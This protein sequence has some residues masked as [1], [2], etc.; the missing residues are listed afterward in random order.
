MTDKQPTSGFWSSDPIDDNLQAADTS[1]ATPELPYNYLTGENELNSSS[2]DLDSNNIQASQDL[3]SSDSVVLKHQDLDISV[4]ALAGEV[5]GLTANDSNGKTPW[6]AQLILNGKTNEAPYYDST[7]TDLG[8]LNSSQLNAIDDQSTSPAKSNQAD[9]PEPSSDELSGL[10]I[11]SEPQALPLVS[12][13]LSPL[14]GEDFANDPLLVYKNSK[15]YNNELE[16][17]DISADNQLE[18]SKDILNEVSSRPGPSVDDETFSKNALKAYKD[19]GILGNQKQQIELPEGVEILELSSDADTLS[20][21]ETNSASIIDFGSGHDQAIVSSKGL[22]PDVEPYF[23]LE[24]L[25]WNP[26]TEAGTPRLQDNGNPLTVPFEVT[27]W[28]EDQTTILPLDNYPPEV[29]ENSEQP[30]QLAS[31]ALPGEA[32]S[33]LP[34]WLKLVNLEPTPQLVGEG[35]VVISQTFKT[36]A[37]DPQKHWLE[38]HVHDGRSDGKGLIGLEL[39]LDWRAS[40]LE[41]ITEEL[42]VDQVFNHEHL[43]L[44]QNI[45]KPSTLE[46][47]SNSQPTRE[48]LLGIGAAALPNGG[49][50]KPLGY[51]NSDEPQTLFARLAFRSENP[52]QNPDLQLDATLIP[53]AGGIS[54]EKDELLILDHRSPNLWVLQASPD[55]PQVGSHAFTLSKGEGDNA[56]IRHLAVAVREVN[57]PPVPIPADELAAEALRPEVLQDAPLSHDLRRLFRDQDDEN[58]QYSLVSAPNWLEVDP[59]TGLLSGRPANA[60]VGVF[61]IMVMVND[62]RGGEAQQT[63]VVEVENVNDSPQVGVAIAPPNL[64]QGQSFTYRLPEGTFSDP[65]LAVDPDEQLHY[66]MV[67]AAGEQIVPTWIQ[68][69]RDSGTLSG[70]AGA[71]DVGTNKLV[72]R[73]IDAA[74]LYAD[75]TVKL[76][77]ENVND[78]PY[79][80]SSLAD[81]LK[82]QQ[83]TA[84]GESPPSEDDPNAL[85]TG[86]ERTFDLNPWF[87]D[88]D[89][90]IV[91]EETLSLRVELDPGTGQIIDLADQSQSSDSSTEWLQWDAEKGVLIIKPGLNEIGEHILRVRATDVGGLSASAIV[92]LLVRHRNSAPIL[93]ITSPEELLANLRGEGIDAA[94]ALTSASNSEQPDQL[95]GLQITLSEES[96][97]KIELPLGL[98][99]DPDLSIDPAELLSLELKGATELFGQSDADANIQTAFQFDPNNLT[100]QGNTHGLGL[101][102]TGGLCQWEATLTATD[103]AGE[104][105]SF[106]LVFNL[107]RKA[108]EPQLIAESDSASLNEGSKMP[109]KDLVQLAVKPRDGERVHL[110]LQRKDSNQQSLEL[111]DSQ[112]TIQTVQST[113]NSNTG[114]RWEIS[115]VANE[116][117]AKLSELQF[118]VPNNSHAIGSFTLDLIAQTELGETGILSEA[119]NQLLNF[120]LEPIANQP[121]WQQEALTEGPKDPFSLT[122]I[123]WIEMKIESFARRISGELRSTS[124]LGNIPAKFNVFYAASE[125][126]GQFSRPVIASS[127]VNLGTGGCDDS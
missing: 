82:L 101:A 88:P 53:A 59:Q 36:D 93:Q 20:L 110:I 90:G 54:L 100:I 18:S 66:E 45:G 109:L 42:T 24:S 17:V 106:D 89:M 75:Q 23:N 107:Q 92:P 40:A 3:N 22:N 69:D 31:F 72:V 37:D 87:N 86:L 46:P 32:P 120:S 85:F 19:A 28:L 78:A 41:L 74:G 123:G 56:K 99:S 14:L 124:N 16:D 62:G 49:Q 104:S 34:D 52:S 108:N 44:F 12:N 91:P 51:L 65:D 67:A 102:V 35:R 119:V 114:Q 126:F 9:Q 71:A 95:I 26:L 127:V 58:L 73:A 116:I 94:K 29:D 80:T 77:V 96:S 21:T 25:I 125:A 47:E 112:G 38:I 57:D 11:S 68:I 81:F 64:L 39:N 4:Q 30:W 43:P 48:A 2:L 55:Q 15:V 33:P 8:I 1:F 10:F 5:P 113:S 76:M 84:V 122:A 63:L 117:T 118:R 98:F 7:N 13:N 6:D 97:T 60:D 105:T 27:N 50:G 83:P 111:I 61:N 121:L 103:T 79:R 70:T 115:G